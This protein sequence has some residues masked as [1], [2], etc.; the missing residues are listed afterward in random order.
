MRCYFDGSQGND[1]RSGQWLTLAGYMASDA[2]WATFQKQWEAMLRNRY[3]IAPYV[4]MC[5]MVANVDPFERIAGWT[6][7]RINQLVLDSLL[8]LQDLDKHNFRSFTYSVDLTAR[9]KLLAEGYEIHDPYDICAKSCV[10]LAFEWHYDTRPHKA[11]LSS[12]FFDRGEA[13]MASIRPEWLREKTPPG[14]VSLGSFWD[15]IVDIRDLD[16]R[17]HPPIQAADVLAWARTRGLSKK[18]RRWRFLEEIMRQII[19]SSSIKFGEIEM[20][21]KCRKTENAEER[22]KDRVEQCLRGRALRSLNTKARSAGI[23]Q[24]TTAE[25]FHIQ[26]LLVLITSTG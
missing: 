11:E 23:A 13:F 16:M 17:E 15:W 25:D 24:S 5:E 4:H 1:D 2:V 21:A 8:I 18:E 9:K 26:P 12:I 22:T 3:P 20:R 19:P 14:K 6:E 7:E 10:A